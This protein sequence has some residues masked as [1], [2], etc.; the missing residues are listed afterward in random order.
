MARADEGVRGVG[1]CDASDTPG[2]VDPGW[3]AYE[4]A[5]AAVWAIGADGDQLEAVVSGFEGPHRCGSTRTT[6]QQRSS[7][8]SSSSLTLPEPLMTM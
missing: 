1:G 5:V 3:D 8:I 6:S 4:D 7:R 2:S